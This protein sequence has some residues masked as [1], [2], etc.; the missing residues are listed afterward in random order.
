M[1]VE[2]PCISVCELDEN[3]VCRGCFRTLEEIGQ[4]PLASDIQRNEFL[5][6]SKVRGQLAQPSVNR[7]KGNTDGSAS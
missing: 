7:A 4:W 6:L 5:R 1:S 2:S 3:N